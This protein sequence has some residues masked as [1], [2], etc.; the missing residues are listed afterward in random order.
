MA[1][2]CV[3]TTKEESLFLFSLSASIC[4]MLPLTLWRFDHLFSRSRVF[5][6]AGYQRYVTCMKIY[7]L[8]SCPGSHYPTVNKC[9]FSRAC[10]LTKLYS[11]TKI[12]FCLA[13][14]LKTN[15]KMVHKLVPC[16]AFPESETAY[17]GNSFG[18]LGNKQN[19]AFGFCHLFLIA[20]L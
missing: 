16:L 2:S 9:T 20:L 10:G 18:K 4:H 7:H 8:L 6:H 1:F 3:Q 13:W 11:R 14:G 12:S 15:C 17:N 5:K 19:L